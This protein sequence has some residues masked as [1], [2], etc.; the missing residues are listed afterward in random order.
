VTVQSLLT[1]VTKENEA[2][3]DTDNYIKDTSRH[4]AELSNLLRVT[5]F[6]ES[7]E[8]VAKSLS[9]CSEREAGKKVARILPFVQRYI[10]LV[11]EQISTLTQWTSSLFKLQYVVCSIMRTVATQGFCT[12]PDMD[13]SGDAKDNGETMSGTG[14]GEGAGSTD[15]S[16]EIED[17]SQVEGLKGQDEERN[18]EQEKGREEDNSAIEMGDDFDG[19]MEDIP[20]KGSEGGQNSDEEDEEGPEEQLGDVDAADP[21]AVDEKLWGDEKGPQEDAEGKTNE[22]HSKKA[23]DDSEVVAKEGER[24]KQQQAAQDKRED[25]PADNNTID[26]P[27]PEDTGD[28]QPDETAPEGAGAPVDDYVQDA[29]T[30]DLPN[31]MDLGTGEDMSED[32]VADEGDDNMS[33]DEGAQEPDDGPDFRDA[34]T[35]EDRPQDTSAEDTAMQD[36]LQAQK[37]EAGGENDD[38]EEKEDEPSE[39]AIGQPDVQS[40]ESSSADAVPEDSYN[41]NVREDASTSQAGGTQGSTGKNVGVGDEAN[42]DDG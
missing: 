29:D 1:N 36:D 34:D 13:E 28:E 32:P 37:Q 30:L 21:S 40:G 35:T 42:P 20:D 10:L 7:L 18:A 26:D 4:L 15:V 25:A 6:V 39:N 31:D 41:T 24:P 12:P 3:D 38:A 9:K 5:P 33:V 22:D 16:K 2:T 23:A 27:L 17:E 19:E 14:L 11:E 8:S